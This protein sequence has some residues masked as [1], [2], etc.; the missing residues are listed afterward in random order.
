MRG[1]SPVSGGSSF[2]KFRVPKLDIFGHAGKTGGRM[3]GR[4]VGRSIGRSVGRSV[5][6]S[7][8]RSVGRPTG[9]WVG[10]RVA[11]QS[12]GRDGMQLASASTRC[13]DTMPIVGAGA[14]AAAP[15]VALAQQ[16]PGAPAGPGAEPNIAAYDNVASTPMAILE[17]FLVMSKGRAADRAAEKKEAE[18]SSA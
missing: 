8:G 11:M 15:G 13:L 2:P 4:P 5:D 18:G 10:C 16:A 6:R 3:V 14:A 1:G 7:V 12:D 9:W 17:D